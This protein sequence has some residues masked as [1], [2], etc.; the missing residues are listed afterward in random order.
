MTPLTR[1]AAS[2]LLSAVLALGLAVVSHAGAQQSVDGMT[3]YLG[4]LPAQ[5][6]P[7][8]GDTEADMHGGVP[9]GR[10]Q[11]HLLLTVFDDATGERRDDLELV[12][13]VRSPG[14]ADQRRRLEPM[15]IAGTITYG[16][17]FR[18]PE[19]DVAYRIG[20]ELRA[21]GGETSR[22]EFRYTHPFGTPR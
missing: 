18:L 6:I 1:P 22:V 17:Y 12:A 16:A 14:L 5:M 13:T 3:V 15:D 9:R 4:V 19:H 8:R 20:V 10:H 21:A 2:I 7:A 11:Y